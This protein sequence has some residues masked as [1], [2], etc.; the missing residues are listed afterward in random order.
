MVD[1][2]ELL[3]RCQQGD[4][5]A[6]AA[7]IN[8]FSSKIFRLA[9]RI[10]SDAGMAEEATADVFAKVWRTARQWRGDS[11]AATWLYRVGY[12]TVIDR[13]RRRRPIAEPPDANVPDPRPGPLQQALQAEEHCQNTRRVRDA[14]EQLS[15][16][17]RGLV[18]L[19]YFEQMPLSELV[20]IVEAKRDVLKMRLARARQKL[21]ELLE[22]TE[23]LE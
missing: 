12:N 4:E 11:Q 9:Y 6:L 18:H 5:S 22:Q 17:D 14:L 16:A 15:E 7:L 1:A 23:E 19:Y 10:L 21:R 13:S 8:E 20:G 2:N 3:R